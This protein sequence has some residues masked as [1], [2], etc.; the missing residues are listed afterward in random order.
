[1]SPKVTLIVAL[2]ANAALGLDPDI[3]HDEQWPQWRGPKATGVAPNADPPVVWSETKNI[4][5]KVAIPGSG[6]S[7]PIIWGDR[8]YLQTA[9]PVDQTGDGEEP[10]LEAREL[11]L[12]RRID[13][14]PDEGQRPTPRPGDDAREPDRARRRPDREGGPPGEGDAPG[15]R[16]PRGGMN[17]PAPTDAYKFTVLALDRQTGKT[18][19]ERVV[20]EAVPH[21]GSHRDGSM[22]PASPVTDGKHL[23]AHFGSRGT[24]CL[25]LDGQVV[26]ETDLGDM[27]TRNGFGEG[28]SPALYGD[29]LVVNWDH[30]GDSFIVALD[31]TTGRQRWRK[32]RDEVTSWATPLILENGGKPLAVVNGTKRIRAYDLATGDVVWECGG[33]TT[34]AIP[35]PVADDKLVYVLSGFRGD[36]LR[37]IRYHEAKGDITDTPAVAWSF[38]KGMPYVPS[39]LL[40]DDTLYYTD[41]N[42][43]LLSCLDAG[44]GKSH[45]DPQRVEGLNNLYA[46]PI[47]AGG[48]VYIAGRDGECLVLKKGTSYEVLAVNKLDDVFDASPATVGKELFLRGRG[49]L[50]CI[51]AD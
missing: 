34:N 28:S 50:Y 12:R 21:E 32:E 3:K 42:R 8:V 36:A 29:S 37:A 26:W 41:K 30:E 11:P 5:W 14:G 25:T 23:Y 48:R 31:K 15:R 45:Y 47:G 33:M 19:W 2:L 51:V 18:V 24:Y 6:L 22:A 17:Q 49:H 4:R 35:T 40:Y 1:M 10:A 46:S 16:G 38:N 43:A 13:G 20:R 44:T 9:I 39:P 7:T 27:K